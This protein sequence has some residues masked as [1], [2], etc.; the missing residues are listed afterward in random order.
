MGKPQDGSS[1]SDGPP[2]HR[3][4]PASDAERERGNIAASHTDEHVGVNPEEG[5]QS[6]S[7]VID[8]VAWLLPFALVVYVALR[9]GGFDASVRAEVGIVVWVVLAVGVAAG[10]LPRL[11][12]TRTAAVTIGLFAALI[13]W[14][15]LAIAWTE[16]AEKTIDELARTLTYFGFFLLAIA[17][18]GRGGLRRTA[19]AVG[20]AIGVVAALALLSRLHPAWFPENQLGDIYTGFES[21][22]NYPLNYWN[23][24]AILVAMGLPL[25]LWLAA[26]SRQLWARALASAALPVMALAI[27]YTF[28][29]SGLI[30]GGIGLVVLLAAY[31]ARRAL[32][33]PLVLGALGSGAVIAFATQREELKSG[34]ES[35][36]ASSQGD[37]MIAIVLGVCVL[38]GLLRFVLSRAEERGVLPEI[39]AG[40]LERLPWR[41]L[42]AGALVVGAIGVLATGEASDRWEEFKQP[43]SVGTTGERFQSAGGNGRYQYWDSAL[44]ATSSEPVT[45][46]G[47]GTYQFWWEREAT[48]PGANEYAHSLYFETLAELGVVG[49]LLILG[50]FG[51]IVVA[52]ARMVRNNPPERRAAPVAALATIVVF[53]LGAGIDWFW[54]IPA[55]PLVFFLLAAAIV[56]AAM[57]PDSSRGRREP[58]TRG[59]IRIAVPLL[60]VPVIALLASSLVASNSIE[61]SQAAARDERLDDALDSARQ[62]SDLQPWAATPYVQEA[63][64]LDLMGEGPD[65]ISAA[66]I[67]TE[68]ESTNWETWWVL[69]QVEENAGE[70]A[71]AEEALG[72]ARSLNPLHYLWQ[73]GG[74]EAA[75]QPGG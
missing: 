35:A 9:G 17:I 61:S 53:V 65:A 21:R 31:P 15:T 7:R 51:S 30:V 47:A 71:A 43:G 13:A 16:S 63:Q 48:L 45:G 55:I 18:Q 33:V 68:K 58:G 38:V 22:L 52:G 46:I 37:E 29:R 67:A 2:S 3:P 23:G 10:L 34:V 40:P 64:I 54:Q 62:A 66:E 69:S 36:T 19:G 39:S 1:G 25:V 75:G 70:P 56:A 41:P 32:V 73:E 14:T 60:A 5:E 26:A 24:V 11:P 4:T 42:I 74:A 57:E 20:A 50:L 59:P 27:Y 49:L 44:A 12:V 6:R 72:R 8:A 28:S